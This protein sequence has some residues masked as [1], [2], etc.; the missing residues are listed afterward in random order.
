MEN[1]FKKE[2]RLNTE[3]TEK[4]RNKNSVR[5]VVKKNWG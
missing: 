4:K 5:S 2:K 3:Y 1:G